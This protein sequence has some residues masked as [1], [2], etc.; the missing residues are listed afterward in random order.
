MAVPTPPTAG[1]PIAEAWGDLVHDAV[2]A[3]DIQVGVGTIAGGASSGTL[4]VVFPRPFASA[5]K[6]FV[7]GT[8][9]NAGAQPMSCTSITTAGFNAYARHRAD[10]PMSAMGFSWLAIGPRA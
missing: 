3:Q 1:E 9:A 10:S 5:P 8:D 2:V 7:S 6:V 4:A